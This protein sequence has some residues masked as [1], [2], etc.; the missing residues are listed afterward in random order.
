V[1][2]IPIL[3]FPITLKI[4]QEL[5]AVPEA[6]KR[7]RANVVTRTP[8]GEYIAVPSP[9]RPGDGHHELEAEPVPTFIDLGDAGEPDEPGVRTVTR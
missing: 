4:C 9:E 3:A 1:I 5:Q 7:K 2:L 8:D 6:G